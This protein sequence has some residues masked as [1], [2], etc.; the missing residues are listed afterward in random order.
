MIK[1]CDR[2]I[3]TTNDGVMGVFSD[4]VDHWVL[5]LKDLK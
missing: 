2:Y 1:M 4:V 3:E 5:L